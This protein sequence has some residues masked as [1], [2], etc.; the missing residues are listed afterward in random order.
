MCALFKSYMEWN[1][2]Q[3]VSTPTTIRI[4]SAIAGTYCGLNCFS[5]ITYICCKLA[6]TKIL[7]NF[8][9]TLVVSMKNIWKKKGFRCF[10]LP[11]R[12]FGLLSSSLLLF[13][14]LFGR[15]VLR[16][17]SG[18]CWTR[19]PT[20]KFELHPLLNPQGSPVLIPLAITG[21]KC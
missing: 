4:L 6:C 15:F 11:L 7:Q 2:A 13:P 12:V 16:L 14:H 18:V 8:G 17:S 10:F 3:C 19:E 1:N 21:Y 20:Q 5:H 9:L